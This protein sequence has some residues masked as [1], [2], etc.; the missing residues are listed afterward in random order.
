MEN[1]PHRKF[2]QFSRNLATVCQSLLAE[3]DIHL[4]V[5]DLLEIFLH[6]A[7]TYEDQF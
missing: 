3:L 2:G 1:S 4:A 7:V 5:T 6:F